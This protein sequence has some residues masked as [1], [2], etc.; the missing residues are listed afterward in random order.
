MNMPGMT[1]EASV[2][3][4]SRHYQSADSFSRL[5]KAIY[6]AQQWEGEEVDIGSLDTES[7][8]TYGIVLP[9][10]EDRFVT[11]MMSCRAGNWHPTYAEC[12]R[13]CCRQITGYESC[14]IA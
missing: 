14:E 2:Y 11:C 9:R 4:T 10:N 6:P 7:P 13:T 12:R 5:N 1:G 8:R 3:Q